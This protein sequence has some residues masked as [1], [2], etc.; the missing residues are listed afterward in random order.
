MRKSCKKIISVMIA[1]IILFTVAPIT[2][3]ALTQND[4]V[5]WMDSKNGTTIYDGGSQC[6]AAFNSYLR[7]WGISSPIS[8][9]PV[10]YAYQIFNYNAPDGWQKISGSGNYQVGDI[11]I[12]DSSVGGGAGHVGMVYSTSGGTVKIFDQNYVA[13]SVCGIHNIA[14]TG[15]IRGV[16]RPPL[17]NKP[18]T[19]VYLD[20]NQY[21]YDIQDTI[22][23]YPH[24]DGATYYWLSIYKDDNHIVDQAIYGEYSFPASQWGYGDYYAWITAGNSAGGTDSAGISFT[25]CGAPSYSDIWTSKGFYDWDENEQIKINVSTVCAKG[26]CIGID[27]LDNNLNYVKRIITENC[28]TTFTVSSKT[29]GI[30]YFSAYFSVYNG[31]GGIDTKKVYFYVGQ[32]KD[33][34]TEFCAK[35]KNKS[36]D[37]YLTAVENNVEGKDENCEKQQVWFFY[38]LSDGSYKIKN[39][40][41]WR[42]LDV[43]NYAEAGAGTNVQVYEDWDSTAQRFYIYELC[44]SYYIKPVCT[45]MVLDMSQ[46]T[47]N[48]EVWGAGFDWNPQKFEIEKIDRSDIGVHKYIDKII[49][50]TI[51][52]EGYTEHICSICGYSYKDSYTHL[53]DIKSESL[54]ISLSTNSY[55]YDGNAKTPTVTVKNDTA[56]LTKDIDYTVKYSNNINAGTATVTVI[57]IGNYTGTLT[58]TF[59]INKAQQTVNA[60]IS[61]NTIDIGNTSTIIA[62]GQGTISYTSSNTDIA[63]V[64]NSGIVTG[65][66][67]GTATITVTATGNNNYNEASKTFTVLVKSAHV[68]GDVNS[69][70]IV[71]I[72]DATEL[73]KYLA[74]II[75]FDDEQLAVAD[76]N[77]DGSVSIADATQIQKYLAQL[78]PSLG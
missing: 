60:T 44:G 40:Y 31:S 33:V 16:F 56:T 5:S 27:F 35:I 68:L 8:K 58:K 50:P 32:K 75:D 38:R 70:G 6:V 78:I 52:S 51:N 29:L 45:D 39:Y 4:V 62:S 30:G 26:Q 65:I 15:A 13:K 17:D 74:N 63:T 43:H 19:N 18:P 23:L 24:A 66:S 21:W 10:N 14:Q 57:G 37:K 2:T 7:I 12:W 36:L 47:N 48:L 20:K 59:I 73:Q 77:G 41:D 28:D 61:S 64:N 55:T 53:F 25:V 67:A 9:Y 22:I 69:D 71:S 76:T 1:M 3:S 54:E 46:T 72:A 49:S 42:A 34:G 11:V